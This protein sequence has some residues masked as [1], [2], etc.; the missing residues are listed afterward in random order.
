ME[1]NP[2]SEVVVGVRDKRYKLIVGDSDREL[3]DLAEDPMEQRTLTGTV[4]E[5]EQRLDERLSTH[6]D[7]YDIEGGDKLSATAEEMGEDMKGRLED[8][9]YL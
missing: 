6:I 8:L 3:Y 2:D 1:T 9:R 4:P 7:K 5:V